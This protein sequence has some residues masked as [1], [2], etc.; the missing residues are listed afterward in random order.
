[1]YISLNG[2]YVLRFRAAREAPANWLWTGAPW[3][4][5]NA[6]R[7]FLWAVFLEDIEIISGLV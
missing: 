4:L 1:M 2:F 5:I 7:F 6:L 3:F